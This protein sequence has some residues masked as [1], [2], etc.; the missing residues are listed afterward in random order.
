MAALARLTTYLERTTG[1]GVGGA[2]VDR[3][4]VAQR[5]ILVVEHRGHGHFDGI[6]RYSTVIAQT[7]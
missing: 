6:A 5:R 2:S 3:R 4:F 7:S 1:Q